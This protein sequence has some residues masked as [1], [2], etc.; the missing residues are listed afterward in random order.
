MTEMMRSTL[1]VSVLLAGVVGAL[2]VL[3]VCMRTAAGRLEARERGA[4]AEGD[5]STR[6]PEHVD[7]LPTG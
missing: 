5:A 3:Y 1:F 4:R 6:S 7:D 2:A